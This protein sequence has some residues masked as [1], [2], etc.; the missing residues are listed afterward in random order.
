MC[1][2]IYFYIYARKIYT[3][4]SKLHYEYCILHSFFDTEVK[5]HEENQKRLKETI[6]S[7]AEKFTQQ[8][9]LSRSMYRRKQTKLQSLKIFTYKN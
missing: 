5:N 6:K 2:C 4:D 3:K 9:L 7:K 8:N 1:I